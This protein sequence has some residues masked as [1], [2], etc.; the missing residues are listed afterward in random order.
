MIEP[1]VKDMS[2]S[3]MLRTPEIADYQ[4]LIQ[5]CSR[6]GLDVERLILK[7]DNLLLI[8]CSDSLVH[9]SVWFLQEASKGPTTNSI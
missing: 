3:W 7:N 4:C 8:Q 1:R 9:G 6:R 5:T 2:N